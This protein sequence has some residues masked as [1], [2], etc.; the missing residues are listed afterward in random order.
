MP[1]H[2]LF[3]GLGNPGSEYAHTRHNFG[4]LLADAVLEACRSRNAVRSLS[5]KGRYE[6]WICS[7]PRGEDWIVVKPQTFM[8]CSGE[9]VLPLLR[10]YRIPLDMLF[11]AHDEL[12]LPFGRMRIKSGGGSAGHKGIESIAT[13]AG[14]PAFYRLRLGIG[15]PT[16]GDTVS[17]VLG[18]FNSGETSLLPQILE[19]G[20]QA[21]YTF[22]A[23]APKEAGRLAN[24]F[25]ACSANSVS[26]A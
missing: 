8:N 6:A 23:G 14:S 4:F 26:S 1:I 24:A 18:R 17:Y 20:M 5:A 7:I 19:T 11:V 13:L 2:G 25:D 22:A 10:Y 9:A 3:A 15:K 21:F 16:G 12:D